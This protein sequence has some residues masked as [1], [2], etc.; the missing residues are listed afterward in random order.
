M[1][2]HFAMK[3]RESFYS[4]PVRRLRVAE[5]ILTAIME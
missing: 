3:I 2:L 1:N 5:A 4:L